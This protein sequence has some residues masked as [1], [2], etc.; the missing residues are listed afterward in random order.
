MEYADFEKDQDIRLLAAV[1]NMD[2]WLYLFNMTG[3]E[4]IDFCAD[5]CKAFSYEFGNESK[6]RLDVQYREWRSRLAHF[7]E[8]DRFDTLLD[9]RSVKLGQLSL[10]AEN[11]TSYI[12]MSMNRWFAADQR[13]MEYMIYH[14][15]EK[16]YR[17]SVYHTNAPR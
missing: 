12:H 11:I 7:M 17:Q 14:F 9:E 5:M 2:K 1:K 10:P 3:E 4:R 15:C 13:L 6:R 8:A 16:Y